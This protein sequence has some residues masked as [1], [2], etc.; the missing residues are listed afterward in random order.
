MERYD[1]E[2]F[3]IPTTKVDPSESI[4]NGLVS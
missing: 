3:R 4:R 2:Q 1:T